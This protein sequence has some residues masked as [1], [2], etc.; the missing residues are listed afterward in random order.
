MFQSKLL[1]FALAAVPAVELAQA[2]ASASDIASFPE[3]NEAMFY[4]GGKFG[5]ES[6]QVTTDDGYN[7]TMFHIT[8][9]AL[10]APLDDTRGPI[11][12]TYGMY[13]EMLDWLRAEEDDSLPSTAVQLA[14]LGYDVWLGNSRG[15]E[16]YSR[17][18]VEYDPDDPMTEAQFW[19]YSFEDIGMEDFSTMIDAIIAH[20]WDYCNKVTLVTHST[21]AN[22]ALVLAASDPLFSERVE[23]IVTLAPCLL[24]NLDKFWLPLK[25]I[26]SVEIFY[27][28]MGMYGVT[29]LF[30]P[31]HNEEVSEFCVANDMTES[32]CAA[33]LL[34]P[35]NEHLKEDG[36]RSFQHVHQNAMTG[37][38]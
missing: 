8:T 20:R 26:E 34:E 4:G 21:G 27:S 29:S 32:I 16:I 3:V 22:A 2:R 31:H 33:Y 25:D 24:T 11:L 35:N 13:S 17:S 5:W 28:Y 36:L 10:G 7:L 6:H 30:G 19:D 23:R 37:R 1:T 12:L 9:D 14:K 18:H 38:F 15:R